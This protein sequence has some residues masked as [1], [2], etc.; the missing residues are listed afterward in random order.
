M[1]LPSSN[2]SKA[3]KIIDVIEVSTAEDVQDAVKKAHTAKKSWGEL[4]VSGR[5]ELLRKVSLRFFESKDRICRLESEEMGMPLKEVF[6]DFDSSILYFESYLEMAE[7][8]LKPSI[9][10]ENDEEVHVVYKEPYGVAACIVPWNFPFA[11]FVW[12]CGENLVT[13]NTVVFK[14]SEESQLCGK[15]I[16]ELVNLVLPEGVF[17]EV[18][19]DGLVGE[20]L[21]AQDVNLICFTGSSKTGIKIK[22]IAAKNLIPTSMELGGSAPGIVFE[23]ANIRAV[24]ETIYSARFMNCGQMCD[25]LKRL[26]VHDSKIDE[27][28][29]MLTSLIKSK[30][31]ADA[32]DLQTDIGPLVAER[33]VALLKEQVSDAISKGGTILVG[34]SRPERLQGAY[35]EPT[36]LTNITRDMRVWNEEVFGPVLPIIS[37]TTEAQAIELANDTP[38]GLGA[39]V[40]TEDN[41]KYMRVAR[42][43]DSGMVSQ[44]NLS[45]INVQNPFTGYK[46]SG[47]GRE[48]ARFGFDEVTQIKVITRQK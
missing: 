5:V 26:I 14:H 22:Q 29:D 36:L 10:I 3:Y 38:Y 18:Y 23:D 11:N 42:Q 24:I 9:T 1:K 4:G 2:P 48:H 31:V 39:Y 21:V 12:Q 35:Y 33:Q 30:K 37:F 46:M 43:L 45:Y 32:L 13:G 41:D 27:V 19:G 16:E 17:G 25:G 7:E 6:D 20:L 44:N 47:G 15:L 34:G 40:F 8:Q 28:T